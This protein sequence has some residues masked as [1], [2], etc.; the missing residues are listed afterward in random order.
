MSPLNPELLELHAVVHG[1][2]Q[3]VGFR[4][5]VQAHARSMRLTGKV[6][7]CV[8][9]TVELIAQGS[10]EQLEGFIAKLNQQP[11]YATIDRIDTKYEKPSHAFEGFHVVI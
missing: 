4:A 10:V 6:R 3:G 11:G 1:S 8:D 9:G 2:V 7:N 5:T